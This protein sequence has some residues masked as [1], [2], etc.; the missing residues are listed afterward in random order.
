MPEKGITKREFVQ[1]VGAG[2]PTVLAMSQNLGM[3]QTVAG[4]PAVTRKAEPLDCS[5]YF[6]ASATDF[7][8]RDPAAGL[9][10]LMHWK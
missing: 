7:G 9:T 1:A 8:P 2:V 5:K 6:T 10:V 4:Q 3:A